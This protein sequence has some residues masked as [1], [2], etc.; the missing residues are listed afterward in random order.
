MERLSQALASVI[1]TPVRDVLAEE[2]ICVQSRGMKQWLSIQL[3]EQFGICANTRFA[4]PKEMIEHVMKSVLHL[5]AE[6]QW[7][8]QDRLFWMILHQLQH[9]ASCPE[10]SPIHAYIQ[11]DDTG[12]KQ[13]QLAV[14][15]S[16]IFDNYLIYRPDMIQDWEQPPGRGK[17]G[18]DPAVQWQ[19]FLWQRIRPEKPEDLLPGKIQEALQQMSD[20]RALPDGLPERIVLFGISTLPPL[21]LQMLHTLSRWTDIHLFLLVPSNQYFFDIPSQKQIEKM[22][23]AH[24][25]PAD[26]DLLHFDMGNPL[27]SSMGQAGKAFFEQIESFDYQEPL[28][29][30][31]EDPQDRSRSM[32]ATLQSDIFNLVY[33]QK[34]GNHGL[35]PLDAADQSIRIHACHSP[36]REAQVLKDLLLDALE[37]DSGLDLHDIV[38]MMPDVEAY[39][40]FIQAVFSL[41]NALEFTISDRKKIS[42]SLAIDGFLKILSLKNTRFERTCV[43]DLL[44]VPPIAQKFQITQADLVRLDSITRDAGILWG[45]DA[46]H[47]KRMALPPFFENTWQFG[48][49]RLFAGMAMPDDSDQLLGSTVPCSVMEGLELELL[50]NFAHFCETLFSGLNRLSGQKAVGAWCNDLNALISSLMAIDDPDTSEDIRE[51]FQ[52]IEDLKQQSSAAGFSAAVSFETILEYIQQKLDMTVSQGNF[53]SGRITFCNLM[54]MRSVPYKI[55]ALMGMDEAAFPRKSPAAGFDLIHRF[56]RQGDRNQRDEDRYLFLETLLSARDRLIITYTGTSVQDNSPIPCSGVVSELMDILDHSFTSDIQSHI[57][58]PHLLHPFDERY[59][60]GHPA[61]FSYSQDNCRIARALLEKPG[62]KHGFLDSQPWIASPDSKAENTVLLEDLIRF[63]KSPAQHALQNRLEVLFP[64]MDEV[65]LER[66]PF[67]LAGLDQ[68]QLGTCLMNHANQAL[69]EDCLYPV[70]KA[71]GV[72]PY[73]L[74]GKFEYLRIKALADP[75]Q[76]AGQQY[77][78]PPVLP[79]LTRQVVVNDLTIGATFSNLRKTGACLLDF[80]QLNGARLLNAWIRHLFLNV[81]HAAP[82]PKNTIL[83][84]RSGTGRQTAVSCVFNPLGDAAVRY[85]ETLADLYCQGRHTVVCFFCETAYRFARALE[86]KKFDLSSA[87]LQAARTAALDTWYGS[88]FMT[89][90]FQNRYTALCLRH[91]DPFKSLETMESS[92]FIHNALRIYQ[93]LLTHLEMDS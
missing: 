65:S 70:V 61:F 17:K 1:R 23:L 83:I 75:L 52:I 39:A 36:M 56:P 4:F 66:E 41:E 47:R 27:L 29:D 58:V 26:A 77:V 59:F 24:D 22:A 2:W 42:E 10:L 15:L 9:H 62:E 28:P 18:P 74:K 8:S 92:G 72:L 38:V 40:P 67:V 86:K 50:G 87:N 84:V 54:P 6:T 85:L 32:L 20:A 76:K 35:L 30:L 80:G 3:A 44:L 45:Q 89:G 90:E 13:H 51:L 43:L 5:P 11:D 37:A 91:Q 16:R 73:G 64:Q 12:K 46:A 69:D 33:R 25:Q 82:Y 48:F 57:Q 53:L 68:Y 7:L 79:A 21:F 63:F 81:C 14:K 49:Y 55:V 60:S 71:R 88:V 34:D 93:P 78:V 19:S 31:F